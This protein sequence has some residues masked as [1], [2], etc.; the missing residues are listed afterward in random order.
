MESISKLAWFNNNNNNIFFFKIVP[1][2][3]AQVSLE[4]VAI[5]Q[6]QSS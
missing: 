4:L 6:T 1:H 5:L 2:S 3:V